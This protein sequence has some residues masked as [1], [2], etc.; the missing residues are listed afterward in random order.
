LTE[1]EQIIAD[2]VEPTIQVMAAVLMRRS[3]ESRGVP[4]YR[5]VEAVADAMVAGEQGSALLAD[6]GAVNMSSGGTVQCDLRVEFIDGR[7]QIVTFTALNPE[8]LGLLPRYDSFDKLPQWLQTKI[9]KLQMLHIPPPRT[10][11]EGLGTRIAEN[12]FWVIRGDD[13]ETLTCA[14]AQEKLYGGNT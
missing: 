7:V 8:N 12:I 4:A 1:L 6:K 10:I 13:G 14:Q 9:I 3:M 11:V 5:M 2:D